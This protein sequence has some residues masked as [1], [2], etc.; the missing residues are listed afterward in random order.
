MGHSLGVTVAKTF[1]SIVCAACGWL[2]L[3]IA[4]VPDARLHV[5]PEQSGASSGG[6]AALA[7]G[8]RSA[9]GG[10]RSTAGTDTGP[11]TPTPDNP[12]YVLVGPVRGLASERGNAAMFGVSLNSEPTGD[13]ALELAPNHPDEVELYP[14]KLHFGVDDWAALKTILVR[15]RDDA[16]QDGDRG[17]RIKIEATATSSRDSVYPVAD[18]E[19]VN[20]DD[21]SPGIMLSAPSAL[22]TSEAAQPDELKVSLRSPPAANVQ[23]WLATSDESE[24]TLSAGLLEFTPSNWNAPQVV[25]VR[26][27]DDAVADGDQ[28]Y[29]VRLEDVTSDDLSYDK[30]PAATIGGIN[31]DDDQAGVYVSPI[32]ELVTSESRRIAAVSIRLRKKPSAVL[33]IDVTSSDPGEGVVE[34]E[35]LVFAPESWTEPRLVHVTG[36]DDATSD[37]NQPYRLEFAPPATLDGDYQALRVPPIQLL[38]IDDDTSGLFVTTTISESSEAGARARFEVNLNSQ[39]TGD[40]L[41]PIWSTDQS[42]GLFVKSQWL[43]TQE[44]WSIA[45]AIEILGVDDEQADGAQPYLIQIGPV[46]STDGRYNGLVAPD[47]ELTNLDDD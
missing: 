39:P 20:L 22:T 46:I 28:I 7:T 41:V 32:G 33:T 31:L 23:V 36:V 26:G 35:R 29:L 12:V 11:E 34:P 5:Q 15:G 24:A 27:E 3:G 21:D 2:A 13:I 42:E 30:L 44:N 19:L 6:A 17:V 16:D 18:V 40:V 25:T 38:N 43:F 37:G 1:S 4:C 8:A 45:Q 10:N 9:V 14:T 47:V